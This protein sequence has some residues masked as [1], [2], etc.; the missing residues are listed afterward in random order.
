MTKPTRTSIDEQLPGLQLAF[1]E[2]VWPAFPWIQSIWIKETKRQ[3]QIFVEATATQD[4][5]EWDD[6]SYLADEVLNAG[7]KHKVVHT[8]EH[9]PVVP[10]NRGYQ[11]LMS[12]KLFKVIAKKHAPW[13]L[14]GG[15]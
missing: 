3:F 14:E 4:K 9:G 13:R 6:F 12:D 11:E 8:I 15:R 10:N 2:L 1:F 5:K 7:E